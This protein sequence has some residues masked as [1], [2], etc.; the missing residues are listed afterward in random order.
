MIEKTI[1]RLIGDKETKGTSKE[2]IEIVEQLL[3]IT[4]PGSFKYMYEKVGN[5]PLFM[6]SFCHFYPIED[7]LHIGN[8]IQFLE[9]NQDVCRWS[10]DTDDISSPKVYQQADDENW[11][12]LEKTP[13]DK[14]LSDILYYQCAMGYEFA[15]EVLLER[16]LLFSF[17]DSGW[18]KVVSFDGLYIYWKQDALIWYLSDDNELGDVYYATPK[19]EIFIHDRHTFCLK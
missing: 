4:L 15:S 18:E 6:S 3:G 17:L 7:L 12:L 5:E 19:E 16:S 9:E 8:K 13:L 1:Q 2:D 10:F 11:Y 14:F